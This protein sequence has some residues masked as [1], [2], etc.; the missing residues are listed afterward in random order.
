MI[1]SE[2][3][4]STVEF[5]LVIPIVLVVM[6]TA[7]DFTR[8]LLAYSAINHGSREGVRY[9]VLHPDAK[10][11]DIED[12]VRRRTPLSADDLSVTVSF[13]KADEASWDEWKPASVTTT[14]D[15]VTVRVDVS[16]P[17]QAASALVAGFFAA[18]SQSLE[19][20]STSFMDM[21]R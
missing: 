21:R 2:R 14:P 17:W 6:L 18:T 20:T 10:E 11:K 13:K 15:T 16:Y 3:G 5:A 9:A 12:E 8:A 7:F 19:L 4:A 1:R